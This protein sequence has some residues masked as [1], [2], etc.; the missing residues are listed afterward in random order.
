ME[1]Y[2]VQVKKSNFWNKRTTE[3]TPRDASECDIPLLA[4]SPSWTLY[5]LERQHHI[6][7]ENI[8]S[9]TRTVCTAP[10]KGIVCH[11]MQESCNKSWESKR[12]CGITALLSRNSDY[13]V[14]PAVLKSLVSHKSYNSHRDQFSANSAACT[15]NIL[16]S[17]IAITR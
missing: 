14:A 13:S 6:S 10:L 12:H 3:G 11:K 16:N 5:D 9:R 2:S 17:Q 1:R 8:K 7:S 4:E 15:C